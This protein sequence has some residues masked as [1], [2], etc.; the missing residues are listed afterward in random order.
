MLFWLL[1]SGHY[2]LMHVSFGIFSVILVMLMNYS[3]SQVSH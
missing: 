3:L 2:D 1:L